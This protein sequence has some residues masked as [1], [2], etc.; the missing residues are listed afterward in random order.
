MPD[1]ARQELVRAMG[2]MR[3]SQDE[4]SRDLD[5]LRIRMGMSPSRSLGRES[6]E[7]FSYE[8]AS[9]DQVRTYSER[10]DPI[11]PQ[12]EKTLPRKTIASSPLHNIADKV[13]LSGKFD[14]VKTGHITCN[15]FTD[16][17]LQKGAGIKLPRIKHELVQLNP[18]SSSYTQ[19]K[20][21][22]DNPMRATRS[23]QPYFSARSELPSSGTY[24][25]S[26]QEGAKLAKQGQPVIV[27]GKGHVGLM[28]DT[29]WPSMYSEHLYRHR[30]T[31]TSHVGIAEPFDRYNFYHLNPDE[32]NQFDK[33]IKSSGFSHEDIYAS[34]G[35]NESGRTEQRPGFSDLRQFLQVR[36]LTGD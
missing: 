13:A 10:I 20:D 34:W 17:I 35:Y 31:G 4:F 1:Q 36:E 2:G 19:S 15:L 25:V 21:W 16:E 26:A 5:A 8:A 14:N 7:V 11:T 28:A 27:I 3:R 6:P 32:Y 33:I 30:E 23:L 18:G 24:K 12:A 29:D 22:K 9:G